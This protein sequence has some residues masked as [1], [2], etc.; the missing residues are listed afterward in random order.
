MFELN[1]SRKI[2]IIIL[3]FTRWNMS[4]SKIYP[5]EMKGVRQHTRV[6][7]ISYLINVVC[8]KM[9]QYHSPFILVQYKKH[10]ER[11]AL[12]LFKQ[13]NKPFESKI[14]FFRSIYK[15]FSSSLLLP[16][17]NNVL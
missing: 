3:M 13:K 10:I 16:T 2:T 4:K 6:I 11:I 8:V 5:K 12:T 15:I 14:L 1:L 17:F 9:F 7:A